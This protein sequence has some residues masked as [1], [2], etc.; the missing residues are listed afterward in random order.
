MKIVLQRSPLDYLQTGDQ[1]RSRV[2]SN[3]GESLVNAMNLL[4]MTLPGSLL[5]YYGD[6]IGMQNTSSPVPSRDPAGLHVSHD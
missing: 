1:D 4:K 5:I 3:V 6:E 2:P